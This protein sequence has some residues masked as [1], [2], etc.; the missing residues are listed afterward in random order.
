MMLR[1]LLVVAVVLGLLVAMHLVQRL[2]L[3]VLV[4]TFLRF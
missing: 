2:V 4:A 1:A 3:V